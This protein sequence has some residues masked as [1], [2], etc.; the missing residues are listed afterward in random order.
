MFWLQRQNYLQ[1]RIELL[2]FDSNHAFIDI[3]SSLVTILG[4]VLTAYTNSY[5]VE[6]LFTFALMVFIVQSLV[7]VLRDNIRAIMGKNG[8]PEV[9]AKLLLKL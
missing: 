1:Y 8:V 2:K 6:L 4:I 3:A 9:E 7:E 5:V